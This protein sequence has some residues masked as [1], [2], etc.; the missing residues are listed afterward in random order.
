MKKGLTILAAALL[1][2][3]IAVAGAELAIT[4]LDVDPGVQ[5]LGIGGAAVSLQGSAETLYYNAAGLA[6]LSG[7][8]FSS[9]YVSHLGLASY[10]AFG[11][12]FRNWGIGFLTLGSGDISGYDETGGG[13]GTLSYGSNAFIVGFGLRP[14][15]LAFLPKLPFDFAL[16]GRLK[17]VSVTSGT[18]SG[19]GFAVDIAYRMTFPDMR[20]GPVTL[21]NLGLGITASNILGSIGFAGGNSETM[22]MGLRVGA[23]TEMLKALLVAAD[24]DLAGRFHLGLQ[25]RITPAFAVRGGIMTQG[26]G[27]AITLG[28]GASVAGFVLDYAFVSHPQLGGSH[29]VSLTLDFS[30]LDLSGIGRSLGRLI[31]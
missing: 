7:A 27:V 25:Y 28:L 16:G 1:G 2:V 13:T 11:L 15:D 12:T 30:S 22:E 26:G 14:S 18:L 31:R 19:S 21:A 23:S 4:V 8:S 10:S 3:G 5:A 6:T 9:S 20:L 24:L 29:R 17:Y